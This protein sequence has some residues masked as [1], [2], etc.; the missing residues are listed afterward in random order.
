M[1]VTSPLARIL[2]IQKTPDPPRR[3]R[4]AP[5][6]SSTNPKLHGVGICQF[7]CQ[8]FELNEQLPPNKKMTDAEIAR[9]IQT[10]YPETTAAKCLSSG[11]RTV[12]HFRKLYNCGTLRPGREPPL[13]LSQR[14]NEYGRPLTTTR[15]RTGPKRIP[16]H[17]QA[18]TIR[19][20]R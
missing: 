10:H 15:T 2:D 7:W 20:T 11:R 6:S 4:Y 16:K 8:L 3:R 17:R 1:A 5:R 9:Q 14:Y 12:Q 13:A 19:T 18:A